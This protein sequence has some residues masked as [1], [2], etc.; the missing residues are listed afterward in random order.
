MKATRIIAAL[1]AVVSIIALAA[2]LLPDSAP[3]EEVQTEE[4]I[5]VVVAAMPIPAFT[6]ILPEML[7]T[8]DYPEELVPAGA[9]FS[10][11]ELIGG[12][13]LIGL[14]TLE[15]LTSGLVLPLDGKSDHMALNL[16]KGMRAMTVSVDDTTGVCNLIRA[17]DRVDVLAVTADM[18]A[19]VLT[20]LN[21]ELMVEELLAQGQKL[22]TIYTTGGD[23]GVADITQELLE[24][25]SIR[26]ERF[27]SLVLL[28]NIEVLALDQNYLSVTRL[29]DGSAYYRTVTLSL[30]PE[31]TELL[32]QV[33][34]DGTVWLTLRAEGDDEILDLEP[35]YIWDVLGLLEEDDG[36]ET[37]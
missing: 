35:V 5:S 19:E 3:Q 11:D 28:Q 36:G 9:Y 20:Q 7:T 12:K 14:N 33:A 10:V 16:E 30:T 26:S 13:T 6:E 32:A 21:K 27:V 22:E 4:R 24:D 1:L 8:A 29:D 17:G 2:I 37:Q 34:K 18:S 25:L 23:T 31:D 15:P